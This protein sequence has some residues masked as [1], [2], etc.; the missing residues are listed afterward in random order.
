M[1]KVATYSNKAV[2]KQKGWKW[3][4]MVIALQLAFMLLYA[5]TQSV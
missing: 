5:M 2:L 3:F 1:M 4:A